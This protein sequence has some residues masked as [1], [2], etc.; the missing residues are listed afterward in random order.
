MATKQ[1]RAKSIIDALADASVAGP[2]VSRI[3]DALVYM[4]ARNKTGLTADDK[5]GLFIFFIRR[6]IK[7]FVKQAETDQAMETARKNVEPTTDI[8]IGTD[9]DIPD[10]HF[11]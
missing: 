1:A 8:D 9:G 7:Q 4:L 10:V 2:T 11:P 5:A 6:Q 3:A